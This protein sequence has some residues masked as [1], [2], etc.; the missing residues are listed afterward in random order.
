MRGRQ[1]LFAHGAPA[2]PLIRL[3]R[4]AQE[5]VRRYVKIVGQCHQRLKIRTTLA[6]FIIL[7]SAVGNF[8]M[9]CHIGLTQFLPFAGFL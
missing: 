9:F 6:S 1:P 7:I 4:A 8:K 5:I 3:L 2:A